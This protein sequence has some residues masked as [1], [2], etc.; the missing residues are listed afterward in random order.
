[1]RFTITIG[2]WT[3]SNADIG[4]GEGVRIYRMSTR[5]RGTSTHTLEVVWPKIR[6]T[7]LKLKSKAERKAEGDYVMGL[8][9]I[10]ELREARKL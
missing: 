4:Y 1:M 8:I 9:S 7:P 10:D 5:S 6:H 2:A 3:L